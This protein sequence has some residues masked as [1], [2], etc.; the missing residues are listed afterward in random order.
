M[1]AFRTTVAVCITV[2]IACLGLACEKKKETTRLDYVVRVL[3]HEP[4]KYTF[5]TRTEPK[6]NVIETTTIRLSGAHTPNI[7]TDVP[8]EAES[9]VIWT[10]AV[11]CDDCDIEYL[12]IHIHSPQ[13]I[14]GAGWDYGK[15]GHGMT[16]VVE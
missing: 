12:A 11:G 13:E 14:N 5:L 4:Q 2:L 16:Q 9:W 8:D 10:H 7:T 15:S 3:M 6:S 1:R